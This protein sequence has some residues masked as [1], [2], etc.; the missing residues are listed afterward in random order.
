MSVDAVARGVLRISTTKIV[1]AVRAITVELGR[2]PA[3]FA[4][5]AFGGGGGLVGVDVA[6]ELSIGTVIVPPGPG[7]FCAFGML[8]ADVRHDYARTLIGQLDRL[9]VGDR[10]G[11]PGRDARRRATPRSPT[12]ASAPTRRSYLMAIDMRY[13][14]Q[15]HSVRLPVA[16]EFTAAEADRLK[17]AFAEAHERA[18]GHTMPDPIEVVAVRLSARSATRPGPHVPAQ[19]RRDGVTVEPRATPPGDPG[20]RHRRRTTPSTTATTSGTATGSPA[21]RSSASTP[22]R[23]CCTRATPPSSAPTA[24]SSS[25]LR[26]RTDMVDSITTEVIRHSMLSAAD[27]MARNLCRTSYNTI[28]YEIH[29]YGVGL[30]DPQGNTIAEAPGVAVFSGA[31]DFGV[32]KAVEFLGAENLAPGDVFMCNYPYWSSA[33]T[34]DV[35]VFSPI[36]VGDDPDRVLL[37]PLPPARPQ[38]EERGLRRR[39][40]EHGAGGD[41][42]PGHEDLRA[43][44]AADRHHRHH[45]LQ[46]PVPGADDRRPAGRGL[47][48]PHRAT[49]ASARSPRSTASTRSSRRWSRSTSTASACRGRP[50]PGSPRARGPRR[51]TSTP[52]ASPTKGRR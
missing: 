44:Q 27:E 45:P 50:S 8:M 31:N 29:D 10:R 38:A 25:R 7:A 24:K 32:R 39:L 41:L 13:E 6:R 9:D 30:H 22:A 23:R 36:F 34:L 43:R 26:G 37:L 48:R 20:R 1:G 33:H 47:G 49:S 5:L 46:Q 3:D 4:L 18:Y 35:L 14:G 11:P 16:G 12:R 19:E 2:N 52:T 42:L 28:V 15:E 51:T 40:H 17:A 21:R